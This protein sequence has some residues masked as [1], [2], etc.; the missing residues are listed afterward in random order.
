MGLLW[1][2]WAGQTVIFS[3][4]RD[5]FTVISV[6]PK[7]RRFILTGDIAGAQGTI[8]ADATD[9][10]TG[11]VITVLD[12]FFVLFALGPYT[13]AN[14]TSQPGYAGYAQQFT[15]DFQGTGKPGCN[16]VSIEGPEP[17]M[18]VELLSPVVNTGPQPSILI[19][20]IPSTT[21]GSNYC[22]RV[23]HTT[24]VFNTAGIATGAMSGDQWVAFWHTDS[25]RYELT[26]PL[27]KGGS[28]TIV[29]L[30]NGA[31]AGSV[32]T[33]SAT[34]GAGTAHRL[35]RSGLNWNDAGEGTLTVH[36]LSRT[37]IVGPTVM[38][39]HRVDGAWVLDPF[40]LTSFPGL[41]FTDH[42]IAWRKPGEEGWQQESL[43]DYVA[44]NRQVVQKEPGGDDL[45]FKDTVVCT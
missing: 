35:T 39:A 42:Q 36:N 4:L 13:G 25:L 17:I 3:V 8:T 41:S 26:V 19:L 7:L 38:R 1:E 30:V 10:D 22:G 37:E 9:V 45:R 11:E 20:N 21:Y 34:A 28:Q 15:D 40:D 23:P 2:V 32:S 18:A 27:E 43:E 14:L 12:A 29:V 33:S 16:I 5:L 6:R 31:D 44:A 24:L